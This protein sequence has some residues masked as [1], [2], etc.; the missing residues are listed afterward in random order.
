M[1]SK[2][3]STKVRYGRRNKSARR[4]EY[5]KA[6]KSNANTIGQITS[7]GRVK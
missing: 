4:P 6:S 1:S 2:A 7:L 5:F 3:K